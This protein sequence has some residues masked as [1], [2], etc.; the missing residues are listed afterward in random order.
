M[1]VLAPGERCLSTSNRNFRGRMGCAEAE[2]VLGSAATVAASA[3]HG[4][5]TDPRE[6]VP[7]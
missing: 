7:Q 5:I 2:I 6:E 4:V 3:L 1:G